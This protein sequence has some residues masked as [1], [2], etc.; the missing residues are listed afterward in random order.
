MTPFTLELDSGKLYGEVSGDMVVINHNSPD[1]DPDSSQEG[2]ERV[3]AHSVDELLGGMA[4]A[5]EAA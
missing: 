1:V 3:H 4:V 2:V 5:T